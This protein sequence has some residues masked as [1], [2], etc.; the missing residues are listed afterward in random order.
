M[1]GRVEEM[2]ERKER[3][4]KLKV[5]RGRGDRERG[6]VKTKY[7]KRKGGRKDKIRGGD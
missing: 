1:G 7:A 3:F 2:K 6:K 4:E 5:E